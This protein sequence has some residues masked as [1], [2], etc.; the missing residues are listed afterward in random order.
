MSQML[1]GEFL[2]MRNNRISE[3]EHHNTS[4]HHQIDD[5]KDVNH[6]IYDLAE[7]YNRLPLL[8]S[9]FNTKIRVNGTPQ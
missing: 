6:H 9:K 3:G 4:H 2:S 5:G 8:R 7:F 1:L